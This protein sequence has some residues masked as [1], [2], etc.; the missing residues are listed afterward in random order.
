MKIT[1]IE[2]ISVSPG[3]GYPYSII[4]VLV[5]T[6]EGLTGIG[7]ASLA[8]RGRGVLGILDHAR[9][10]LVGQ[11]PSRIEHIWAELVRG[12]FWSTGQVIMSAAAGI[13]LALWDLKGKRL[14]VP[15]YDLLGGRTRDKVRVYRHLSHA[16]SDGSPSGEIEKLV[17]EAQDWVSRGYTALR[18]GPIS[19]NTA[20]EWEASTSIVHTIKAT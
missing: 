2:T 11:D 16:G 13:D 9:E 14:G 7:E 12:T 8:G 19:A 6:D 3:A 18:Y 1:D 10:L 20:M 5:R 17:E 4:V 15:V